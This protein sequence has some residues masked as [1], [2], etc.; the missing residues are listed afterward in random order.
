MKEIF[1]TLSTHFDVEATKIT[2]YIKNKGVYESDLFDN[3]F[4]F[5]SPKSRPQKTYRCLR[6]YG[7]QTCRTRLPKSIC[8]E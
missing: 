4:V 6:V 7:Y 8:L 2:E 3:V 5:N 1:K